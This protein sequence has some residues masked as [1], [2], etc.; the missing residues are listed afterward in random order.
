MTGAIEV[1]VATK[2]VI[3]SDKNSKNC[4]KILQLSRKT[5]AAPRQCRDIMA[6]I[7]VDTFHCESVILIVD[8]ENMISWEHHIQISVVSVSTVMFRLGG[9]IH[10]L[11]NGRCRFVRTHNMSHDL[12][13]FSAYHRHYVDV[14]PCFCLGFALQKPVQFIQFHS[15]HCC[16]SVWFTRFLTGLFLS[17]SSHSTY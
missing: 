9:G 6:Q 12:P 15:V 4:L 14:F 2:A 8:I 1:F 7:S 3:R 10:H 17:N 16:C 11:L 5:S 13:R